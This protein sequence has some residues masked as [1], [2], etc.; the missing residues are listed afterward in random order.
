VPVV[1]EGLPGTGKTTIARAVAARCRAAF[2]RVDAIEQAMRSAGVLAAG[3][4]GPA[5]YMAAYALAEAKLRLGLRVV[6]ACVNSLPVTRAVW[7]RIAAPGP[8][9]E[10]EVLC[11][12]SAEHRR[13]VENRVSDVP[14]LVPPSWEAVSRHGY[15]RWTEPRLVVDTAVLSAEEA[16]SRICREI[17]SRSRRR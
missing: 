8:I 10:V 3:G 15:E 14:G 6:A 7:R 17:A 13:R 4:V 16:A 11:S 12:D 9:L 5:G 2:I 1:L